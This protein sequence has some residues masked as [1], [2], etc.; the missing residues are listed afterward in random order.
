MQTNEFARMS[1]L[2]SLAPG[3]SPV[4]AERQRSNRFNGLAGGGKPLKRLAALAIFC[5]RL[6]P[7]V[8]EIA[9]V[10]PHTHEAY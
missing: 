2:I 9:G 10:A 8:N 4:M 5:T 7:G 6:K 1:K 3:F